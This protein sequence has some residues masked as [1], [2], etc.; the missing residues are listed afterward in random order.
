MIYGRRRQARNLSTPNW[1]INDLAAAAD[2]AAL[3]RTR[4]AL[5]EIVR[6]E[7]RKQE[8]RA[9]RRRHLSIAAI[10]LKAEIA[11]FS[12]TRRRD[13]RDQDR[14]TNCCSGALIGPPAT[15][16]NYR[17][18]LNSC[19]CGS[20]ICRLASGAGGPTSRQFLN[21]GIFR[22]SANTWTAIGTSPSD[23]SFSYVS[24]A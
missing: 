12:L 17:R 9:T 2:R 11:C 5:Q 24:G 18:I 3:S 6:R 15:E 22:P 7:N 20:C 10:R 16:P 19:C 8:A 4:H 23:S 1:R 14:R 21:E 13:L